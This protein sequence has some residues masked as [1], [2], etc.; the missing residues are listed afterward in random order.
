MDNNRLK[1]LLQRKSIRSYTLESVSE[2]TIKTLKSEATYINTHEA[3]LNFNVCQ[4]NES[5]FKGLI[6]SYGMFKNVRNYL[7]AII[8]PTFPYAEERAGFFAQ[9]WLMMAQS[10]GLGTC[11]VGATF[12][13]KDV[14]VRMEVYEK[15]AF[16]VSFGYSDE[17]HTS[18]LAKF[19]S[20]L[21]HSHAKNPRDFFNGDETEYEYAREH[22]PWL[23]TA[24]LAVSCAPSSMNKQPV[25]LKFDKNNG[26]GTIRAFTIDP[27]KYKIELGI[28]K[29]N[30][31]Y[32][33]GGIWDWGENGLFYKEDP[34][35]NLS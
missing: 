12:S 21:L 17:R 33:V 10:M 9:Q 14:Q 32:A 11:F 2:S 19:T 6:K 29:F 30:I 22:L 8:D 15:L 23:D 20:T 27:S 7:A 31:S 4:D 34:D 5:A 1:E 24:L 13:K 35:S 28:S 3:G 26:V 25:R 16:V 18:V